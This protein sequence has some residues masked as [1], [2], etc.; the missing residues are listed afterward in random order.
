[1]RQIKMHQ[2]KVRKT[3]GAHV[4]VDTH[5]TAVP[6]CF[7]NF[8]FLKKCYLFVLFIWPLLIK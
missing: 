4:G 7:F 5:L 3:L 1:M 8:Y 6:L 2:Y